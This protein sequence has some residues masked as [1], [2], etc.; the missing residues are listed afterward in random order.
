MATP[1]ASARR[2]DPVKALE[3]KL[4]SEIGALPPG[5]MNAYIKLP[6]KTKHDNAF[7]RHEDGSYS[8]RPVHRDM[9]MARERYERQHLDHKGWR[10]KHHPRTKDY[11]TV[12]EL[13]LPVE[14]LEELSGSYSAAAK[15]HAETYVDHMFIEG[16]ELRAN[17]NDSF[18]NTIL[19]QPDK[20][21]YGE[22]KPLNRKLDTQYVFYRIHVTDQRLT[23]Q[24]QTL[25][26]GLI[27]VPSSSSSPH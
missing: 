2:H 8:S 12:D 15:L 6:I 7:A 5:H 24:G 26:N 13:G 25:P 14:K 10:S 18:A 11:R 20:P 16:A 22:V 27:P 23:Q 17:D 3:E 4:K 1:G 9:S 19:L 21:V